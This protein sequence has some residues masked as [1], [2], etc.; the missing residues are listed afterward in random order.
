MFQ[1]MSLYA[2]AVKFDKYKFCFGPKAPAVSGDHGHSKLTD[3]DN[4]DNIETQ[5]FISI[6]PMNKEMEIQMHNNPRAIYSENV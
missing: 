3:D 5:P 4:Q 1:A 6:A 2:L